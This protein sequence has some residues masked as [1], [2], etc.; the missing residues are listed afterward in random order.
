LAFGKRNE[1]RKDFVAQK[2]GEGRTLRREHA[3]S[4]ELAR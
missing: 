1:L 4:M 2:Y 3:P